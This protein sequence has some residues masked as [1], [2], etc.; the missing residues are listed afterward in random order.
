VYAHTYDNPGLLP[1]TFYMESRILESGTIFFTA[2][3][4]QGEMGLYVAEPLF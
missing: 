3:N 2:M 1:L 4:E